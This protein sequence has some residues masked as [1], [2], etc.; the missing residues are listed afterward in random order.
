MK[1]NQDCQNVTKVKQRL[2]PLNL[3]LFELT[4][5][6]EFVNLEFQTNG[7][8]ITVDIIRCT[9]RSL[10]AA[11]GLAWVSETKFLFRK[12]QNLLPLNAFTL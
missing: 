6:W 4:D 9:V 1:G 7:N 11:S 8:K 3:D 12:L 2:G 10:M 5:S